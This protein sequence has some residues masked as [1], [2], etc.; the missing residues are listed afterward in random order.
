VDKIMKE[1]ANEGKITDLK[2][3]HEI[4]KNFLSETKVNQGVWNNLDEAA[5]LADLKFQKVQ[6]SLAKGIII[7]V[8][9]VSKLMAKSGHHNA[10]DTVGSI[11]GGV[12]L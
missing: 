5:R 7:I 1:K 9:E 3:Q 2:K 10:N 8:T 6:I 11:M 4:P 12:L